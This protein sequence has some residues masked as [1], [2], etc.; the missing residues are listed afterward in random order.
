MDFMTLAH[1]AVGHGPVD[2]VAFFS[3][4]G[5]GALATL[6]L[7]EVVLGIDN[8]VFLAILTNK[9]D[10][11]QQKIARRI[12]LG[13]ALV[14][15]VLL[16]LAIGW[17]MQLTKPLF[18]LPVVDHSF[19]GRDLI[20]LGGGLFLLTK[21][22]IEIYHAVEGDHTGRVEKRAYASFGI[23]VSQIV[24]MDLIFSLD[25]VITA[26]GMTQNIPIMITAVVIAI[27]I[28]LIFAGPISAFIEKHPSLKLLAL[29]FL[30]LI[31]VL[32]TADGLGQ[33]L[34]R[35]YVYAAMAFSIFVELLQMRAGAK[36]A[37]A[38][39]PDATDPPPAE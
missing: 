36:K 2:P 20:L 5:L 13:L 3:L 9:L 26:V 29:A 38:H 32:L 24:A 7:L 14:A 35:G 8:I 19:S 21:A 6:T 11:K 31:G 23:V 39:G 10:P 28:M 12:G 25:S 17:M 37:A 16:L 18:T 4:A 33:H 1:A 30:V 15:R 22:T 27:V 34:P